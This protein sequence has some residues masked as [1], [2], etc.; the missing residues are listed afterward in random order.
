[1]AFNAGQYMKAVS[2]HQ[3]AVGALQ[4]GKSKA[5]SKRTQA[6]EFG[7]DET[8]KYAEKQNKASSI[9]GK[10]KSG[11]GLLGGLAAMAIGAPWLAA[12]ILAGG[13]TYL[14]G[15]HGKKK[16]KEE[17]DKSKFFK[18]QTGQTMDYMD[19]DITKSTILAAA[20]AAGGAHLR[21]A[22]KAKDLA[23]AG[24]ASGGVDMTGWTQGDVAVY[25]KSGV[26]PE[27]TPF[28]IAKG[29]P[30]S[31]IS[32]FDKPW[33]TPRGENVDPM[34]L[35]GKFSKEA[36]R[37]LELFSDDFVDYEFPE[38]GPQ[39]PKQSLAQRGMQNLGYTGKGIAEYGKGFLN[40]YKMFNKGSSM[41]D[42]YNNV[43]MASSI[44]GAI[45]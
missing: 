24:E 45:K 18:G 14:G 32:T 7:L 34:S 9:F 36:G 31:D 20:T 10:W 13:S 40:S 41:S 11:A 23:A 42:L 2:G 21:D 6:Q 29:Q 25:E 44:Y 5:A 27:P 33:S 35:E 3:Q 16:A 26:V 39:V 38:V 15:K 1:M 17:L 4:R 19:K 37:D 28:E 8:V 30:S 22:A 12:A 43:K